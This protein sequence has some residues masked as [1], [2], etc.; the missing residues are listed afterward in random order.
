MKLQHFHGLVTCLLLLSCG[1]AGAATH[2][3]HA[4]TYGIVESVFLQR[5]NDVGDQPLA[6]T[7]DGDILITDEDG[8]IEGTYADGVITGQ[9]AET[10][11]DSAAINVTITKK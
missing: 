4:E 6:T 5:D 10:G 7:R 2:G 11:A 8:F 1:P 9:Y 3:S